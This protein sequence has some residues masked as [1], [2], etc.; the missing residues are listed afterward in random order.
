MDRM[1]EV[2]TAGTTV[3]FVSHN[4]KAVTELCARSMLLKNG[5]TAVIG[6][7]DS[8]VREYLNGS[9]EQYH[10]TAKSRFISL[11]LG[12]GVPMA[13]DRRSNPGEYGV[14]RR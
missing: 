1:R 11:M 8:V 6:P 13:S 14:P 10:T 3:L 7:T 4:L 2:L 5:K 12:S 9:R